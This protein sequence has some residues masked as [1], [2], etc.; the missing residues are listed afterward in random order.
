MKGKHP[1]TVQ[2]SNAFA[3]TTA[4]VAGA[5]SMNVNMYA[6]PDRLV[7][8]D[9]LPGEKKPWRARI[10]KGLLPAMKNGRQWLVRMSDVLALPTLQAV[11]SPTAADDGDDEPDPTDAVAMRLARGGRK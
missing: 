7:P 4:P 11:P 1:T 9:D 8:L 6:A 3:V 5:P 2:G 10:A